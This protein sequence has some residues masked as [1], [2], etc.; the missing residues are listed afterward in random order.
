MGDKLK[1]RTVKSKPGFKEMFHISFKNSTFQG[2]WHP[3][4][5]DGFDEA[6]EIIGDISFPYPEPNL[7]RISC[8]PTIEQCFRGVF[9]NVAHLFEKKNYPYMEY[10]VFRPRFT[11]KEDIILPAEL[12]AQRMIWDACVTEETCI[13]D[14]VH[15]Q[16][17]GR[18]RIFNTN[19]SPTMFIHPFGDPKNPL[20]S[21][22][23]AT[24][25]WSW[26]DKFK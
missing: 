7:P 1:Y 22:G 15:M 24:I 3:N 9:P 18:V 21:V 11:G 23:P 19:A 16:F 8:S 10:S 4:N 25:K 20:E 26:I 14:P 5:P 12:T 2:M 13:L 17:V 6:Q